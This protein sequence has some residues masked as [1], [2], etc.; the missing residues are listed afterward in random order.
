MGIDDVQNEIVV[1]FNVLDSIEDKL[2]FIMELGGDMPNLDDTFKNSTNKVSGCLSAV[3]IR[4][5]DK[6]KKLY[7]EGDSNTIITKGLLYLLIRV[8]SGRKPIDILKS[9]LFFIKKIGLSNMLG[10]QR[11]GGYQN[12]INKIYDYSCESLSR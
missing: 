10:A 4:C 5:I 11:M 1:E 2:E 9:K 8:Y 7:F 6:N 3:W 12:M